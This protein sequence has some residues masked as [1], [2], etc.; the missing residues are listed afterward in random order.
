MFRSP[1]NRAGA[2]ALAALAA[3][4]PALIP[5]LIP[6]VA[7][8]QPSARDGATL[9]QAF[10]AAWQRQPEA[11]SQAARRQAAEAARR[12]ASSWLSDAPALDIAAKSDRLSGNDG[13]REYDL[14][15]S[16]PLWLPGERARAGALAEAED[17]AL[18][19]KLQASRLRLAAT[20]REAWWAAQLARADET[21]A[22]ARLANA[23]QLADDTQRRVRAGEL[24]RADR[25]QA[26][27]ALAQAEGVLAEASA[28]ASASALALRAL[29]GAAA[30]DI[31]APQ[32][33]PSPAAAPAADPGAAHPALSELRS[34]A[35][36]GERAAELAAT[37]SRANPELL[38]GTQ[39]ERDQYGQ[40]YHQSL[41]VG[42]RIP[43]GGG[44]RAEAKAASARADALEAQGQ[45]AVERERL[46]AEIEA[47]RS[48]V[49]AAQARLAA[50]D[51][52]SQLAG[53]VRGFY[54]RAFKL[55]EADLPT[56][57]R[58][59]LDAVA[60]ERQAARLRIE[61]AAAV[62]AWRQA[63]GLLPQ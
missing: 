50:A 41:I 3:R 10:D 35:A 27:G 28:A 62:S 5:A 58:V 19:T 30:A 25:A 49:A 36:V 31:G 2:V 52:Q 39:R 20:V 1:R 7:P 21:L 22:R 46:G 54:D 15:L 44:D 6:A 33:E 24:A 60:A 8:A 45:L 34:R 51:K 57:L 23:Q 4:V 61:A 14:A 47:A 29:T 26:D 13:L 42:I 11:A 9:P 43:F 17:A 32:P 40:P 38:L 48:R 59:E 37:R 18:D 16:A 56:R 63:L 55:G 53:Q 12:A